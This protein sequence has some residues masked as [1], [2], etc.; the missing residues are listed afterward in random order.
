MASGGEPGIPGGLGPGERKP[1][2]L[3]NPLPGLPLTLESNS[4]ILVA[5]Q[6]VKAQ[7]KVPGFRHGQ[8]DGTLPGDP[9]ARAGVAR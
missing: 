4:G 2:P 8:G 7:T 5:P 9:S 1:G 3:P 6:L